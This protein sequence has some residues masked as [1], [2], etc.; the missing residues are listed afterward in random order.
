MGD[1]SCAFQIIRSRVHTTCTRDVCITLGH[2]TDKD[3]YRRYGVHTMS[4]LEDFPAKPLLEH[5]YECGRIAFACRG[6]YC[7]DLLEAYK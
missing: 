3:E 6:N 4:P 2:V 7:Q 1:G 5:I